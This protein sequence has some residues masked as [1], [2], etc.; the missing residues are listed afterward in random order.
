MIDYLINK[1]IEILYQ[2]IN[3]SI[4]II[5]AFIHFQLNQLH[6]HLTIN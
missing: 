2:T 1:K 3:I 4:K 6:Q 5:Q